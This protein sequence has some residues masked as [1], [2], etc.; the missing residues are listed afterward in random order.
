MIRAFIDSS[1]FFSACVSARGASREIVEYRLRGQISLVTSALVL[2]ETQ[3]NLADKVPAALA[4]FER[5]TTAVPFEFIRPSRE[6]VQA[7]AAYTA[8]KDAPIVAAARQARAD[9]L[10]T[11]DRR[12]LLDV[13]EV[14]DRSGLIIVLPETLLANI[15]EE[16][17]RSSDMPQ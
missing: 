13:P 9:Y 10:C 11:L 1:V 3:R 15:R 6:E 14:S 17:D 2:R 7:A 16:Q 12:H 8:L 5:F 4:Q